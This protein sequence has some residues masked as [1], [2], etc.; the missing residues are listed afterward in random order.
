[1]IVARIVGVIVLLAIAVSVI[2]WVFT[3]ENRYLWF[4]YRLVQVTVVAGIVFFGIFFLER[5]L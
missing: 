3:R 4:A 1:M 2:M 5:V